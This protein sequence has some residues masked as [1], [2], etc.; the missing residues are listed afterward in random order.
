VACSRIN[1]VTARAHGHLPYEN[2]NTTY[3]D[4][5]AP[6][7][8]PAPVL[9]AING[10][11]PRYDAPPDAEAWLDHHYQST[12]YV[13][14][15]VLTVHTI[16]DPSV[17]FFHETIFG[18]LVS[19]AGTGNLVVQRPINRYGHCAITPNELLAA[20]ADLVNWVENDVKPSP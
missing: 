8:V 15:P 1:D 10:G 14:F 19:G 3:T 16:H 4:L 11:V 2:I 6:V 13:Q 7:L 18:Q 12:G 5:V 9:A 17:P 20:F